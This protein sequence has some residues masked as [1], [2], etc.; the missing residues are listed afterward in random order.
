MVTTCL[1]NDFFQGKQQDEKKRKQNEENATSLVSL[2]VC[3]N[4]SVCVC[5]CLRVLVCA[6]GQKLKS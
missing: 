6:W 3:A 5:E 1:G 2:Y 4:V